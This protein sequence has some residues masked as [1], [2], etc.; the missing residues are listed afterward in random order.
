MFQKDYWERRELERRRYP[1]H[2][3]V[4]A[5]VLPKIDAIRNRIDI[6]DET[7]L[8]DVG[9]GNGFFTYYFDKICDAWGVDYSER[10][11]KINP[12]KN[13]FAA[14]VESDWVRFHVDMTGDQDDLKRIIALGRTLV[15]QKTPM[16]M[17]SMTNGEQQN[18]SI[19]ANILTYKLK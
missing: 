1:D 3:V 8:L 16:E 7:R 6:T 2:P 18:N 4:A 5:H 13:V 15:L 12:V 11:L 17:N 14:R 10:M 19:A 9:C